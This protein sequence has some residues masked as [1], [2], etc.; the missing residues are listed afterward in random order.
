MKKRVLVALLAVLCLLLLVACDEDPETAII[1]RWE[2]IDTSV[3]HEWFCLLIF[4]EDGRFVDGDGD[5][6]TYRIS[7][8]YLRLSFDEFP[9]HTFTFRLSR[10]R[11]T[12]TGRNLHII[13][14]RSENDS[15]L[16]PGG[17]LL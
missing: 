8:N 1:G 14:V 16:P 5:W 12:H 9:A 13:L 10:N 2:C 15:A 6:G 7:D 3:P 11:L 17:V 4:Y